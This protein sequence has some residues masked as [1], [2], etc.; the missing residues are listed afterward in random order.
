MG[1]DD[2]IPLEQEFEAVALNL[3]L[4]ELVE[5]A[6]DIPQA[7]NSVSRSLELM[8]RLR[9]LATKA[10]NI[11]LVEI[12]TELR[13]ELAKSKNALADAVE[14]V[15]A[16]KDA[17]T[18]LE[19]QVKAL[20]DSSKATEQLVVRNGLYYKANGDGPFCTGCFDNNKKVIR[21]NNLVNAGYKCPVCKSFVSR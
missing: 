9:S 3:R 15:A 12:I 13:V 14:E 2:K 16:L 17:K 7:V 1:L 4:E 19:Q 8:D 5:E 6:M 10:N 20:S 11:E 18:K 21:M